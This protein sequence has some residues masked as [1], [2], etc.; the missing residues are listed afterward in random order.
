M[1]EVRIMRILPPS[2]A[3]WLRSFSSSLTV[4]PPSEITSTPGARP[5]RPSYSVEI[6]R[7]TRLGMAR[8]GVG[9]RSVVDPG[10]RSHGR[11][12]RHLADELPLDRR[13][14]H[15]REVVEEGAQ[16]GLEVLDR[17][18]TLADRRVDVAAGVGAELDLAG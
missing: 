7:L 12:D 1:S 9:R 13:R 2:V 18:R 11:R 10:A 8:S 14:T 16:V 17:E 4:T 5:S 15:R 6:S 3:S